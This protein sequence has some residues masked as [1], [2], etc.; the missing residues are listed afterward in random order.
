MGR[1]NIEVRKSYPV[2]LRA[3]GAAVLMVRAS[4][5]LALGPSGQVVRE[6][7]AGVEIDRIRIQPLAEIA[8]DCHVRVHMDAPD[9]GVFLIHEERIAAG[10]RPFAV[11]PHESAPPYGAVDLD[12][13]RLCGPI[14]LQP[15]YGLLVSCDAETPFD[16]VGYGGEYTDFVTV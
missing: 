7:H 4:P 13:A 8:A 14:H 12:A 10:T 1:N 3:A 6:Y 15:S 2:S 9:R 5:V 16:V 11:A